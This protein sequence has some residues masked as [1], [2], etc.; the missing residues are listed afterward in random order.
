MGQLPSTNECSCFVTPSL[1]KKTRHLPSYLHHPSQ[2]LA[3]KVF[4]PF[5]NSLKTSLTSRIRPFPALYLD[6][7]TVCLR[8]TPR[9]KMVPAP[10]SLLFGCLLAI[11]F[12]FTVEGFSWGSSSHVQGIFI[13]QLLW[14]RQEANYYQDIV[15]PKINYK[16]PRSSD[17]KLE[18]MKR[19]SPTYILSCSRNSKS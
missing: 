15:A 19:H 5:T 14:H 6:D 16:P 2:L 8:P 4:L 18:A 9:H 3:H 1:S 10:V 11:C 12:P 13:I 7:Q 17:K